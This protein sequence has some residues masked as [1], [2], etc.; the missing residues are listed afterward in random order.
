METAYFEDQ[1]FDKINFTQQ[2]FQTGSYDNCRFI[3]CN[4]SGSDLSNSSFSDCSFTGCNL[5]MVQLMKTSFQDTKFKD[6]KMLG[7]H[8]HNC[9]PFLFTADFDNCSLNVSSFY[10]LK[11]K[12]LRFINSSLYDVDFTE[13]DL[14]DAVFDNCD[15]AMASFDNTVLLKTNFITSY[16]FS[17]DPERNR[18]KKAKF[19]ASGLAGLLHKYDLII[20]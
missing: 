12:K 10:Q 2:V 17:I 11:L 7:L 20:E 15:L 5:S 16:N 8:F 18:M 9:N 6:C 14:T 13:A 19:P 4:L 3:N 1:V